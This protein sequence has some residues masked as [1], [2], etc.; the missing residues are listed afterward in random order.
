MK[1]ILSYLG[2]YF[3]SNEFELDIP[4]IADV[5]EMT[6]EEVEAE[7]SELQL[8]GD[9]S[10]DGNKLTLINI[11]PKKNQK[12]NDLYAPVETMTWSKGMKLKLDK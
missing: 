10:L 12:F 3:N 4:K 7:L 2:S 8:T 11:E 1:K 6:E 9:I 5:S